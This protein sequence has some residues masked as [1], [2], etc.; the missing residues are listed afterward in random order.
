MNGRKSRL[1]Q[2]TIIIW[3]LE[4]SCLCNG[5]RIHLLALWLL[6]KIWICHAE[7][8]FPRSF[9][10]RSTSCQPQCSNSLVWPPVA[11]DTLCG[12]SVDVGIT[13]DPVRSQ[14]S[15]LAEWWGQKVKTQE[16]YRGFKAFPRHS[17]GFERGLGCAHKMEPGDALGLRTFITSE[18]A[19]GVWKPILGMGVMQ[20]P[21]QGL[22][23]HQRVSTTSN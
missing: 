13:A 2:A 10:F 19:P 3:L 20:I 1:Y 8:G 23:S 11:L 4:A 15:G 17:E 12:G 22:W 14:D 7:G 16:M 5:I 18:P 6:G 9:V 21:S